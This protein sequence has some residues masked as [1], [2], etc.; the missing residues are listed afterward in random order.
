MVFR[1]PEALLA[2]TRKVPAFAVP[3]FFTVTFRLP[4]EGKTQPLGA[5]SEP[6]RIEVTIKSG[7]AAAGVLVQVGVGVLVQVGGGVGLGSSWDNW[8][9]L[10]LSSTT[11]LVT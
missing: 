6:P 8:L 10:S 3:A 5:V 9:L 2:S 11:R 7:S 1:A 4:P